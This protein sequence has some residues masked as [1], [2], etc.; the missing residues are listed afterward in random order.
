MDDLPKIDSAQSLEAWLQ[1]RPSADAALI[2]HRIAM[3]VLPV[4][5]GM[6]K[7]TGWQDFDW[8]SNQILRLNLAMSLAD[9]TPTEAIEAARVAALTN[10]FSIDISAILNAATKRASAALEAAREAVNTD[11]APRD[12]ALIAQAAIAALNS[13]SRRPA[14]V[15][16]TDANSV[17]VAFWHALE[18]DVHKSMEGANIRNAPLWSNQNPLAVEWTNAEAI[19]QKQSGGAFWIDWYQ[20]A[21][22]GRPQHTDFLVDIAQI[23]DAVWREGGAA[24]DGVI[25]SLVEKHRQEDGTAL[26]KASPVDFDFDEHLQQMQV[27]G[28]TDDVA[29]LSDPAAIAAFVADAGELQEGLQDYIDFAADVA[30]GSNQGLRSPLAAQ[31]LL[32][33]LDR[34]RTTDAIRARRLIM[35]G[36]TFADMALDDTERSTLGLALTNMM[37]SQVSLLRTIYRKHLAPSLERLRPLLSLELGYNNPDELLQAADRL[38][39]LMKNADNTQLARLSPEALAVIEDFIDELRQNHGALADASSPA[40][41]ENLRKRFAETYGAI[42]VAYGRYVEKGKP[43]VERA[44]Q[45][46]DWVIKQYKRW[47]TFDQIMDTL[48]LCP[49]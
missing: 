28:F 38:A 21:L 22:N 35:L 39:E 40:R 31:K 13:R 33:E 3:R 41:R 34:C 10:R 11:I 7:Y 46:V 25:R 37:D 9:K 49:C 44:G 43:H 17:A 23:P 27:V 6:K 4:W 42:A 32:K 19:L 29:H 47:T 15:A 2:A 8:M 1:T 24:L 5:W 20:S 30:R 18:T 45:A 12:A 14:P 48:D 36:K 16:L 26:S